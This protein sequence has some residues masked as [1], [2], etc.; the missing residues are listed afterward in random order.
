MRNLMLSALELKNFKCFRELRI[1]FGKLTVLTGMND[2][3]KSSVVQALLL[4][5]QSLMGDGPLREL[6]LSGEFVD[7]GKGVDILFEHSDD[8]EIAFALEFGGIWR[9]EYAC[10]RAGR[11]NRLPLDPGGESSGDFSKESW[12]D[13]GEW[14]EFS[15]ESPPEQ[16]GSAARAIFSES[17]FHYLSAERLGPR[18]SFP[19]PAELS[20]VKSVGA[21]GENVAAYLHR[22]MFSPMREN[23]PRIRV[24]GENLSIV[25]QVCDW[26]KEIIPEK[27][28]VLSESYQEGTLSTQY[29]RVGVQEGRSRAHADRINA[30]RPT[31]SGFGGSYT[32]PV[33]TTLLA[34]EPG[35][36][37]IIEH[38]EAHL[39]PSGQTKLG[40]LA[41]RAAMAGVQV[42]V[43][44]H[45][46]CF[47]HGVRIDARHERID[48]DA[49]NIHHFMRDGAG[50]IYIVPLRIRG[51]GKMSEWPTGFFDEDVKNLMGLL[52]P[53]NMAEREMS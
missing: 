21:R 22:H 24:Q 4:L 42:V 9:S 38:P 31:D 32:L 25:G 13:G 26:F 51:D 16:I 10:R 12:R 17:G 14:L 53:I 45:S 18:D 49:V 34:A 35:D 33:L 1:E 47:M 3:G 19:R 6:R 20:S 36:M 43:E 37:V 11:R 52:G 44:T 28:L 5:R 46:D 8:K 23:D 7:L 48:R 27:S 50:Q 29:R 41:G 2:M 40:E 39:H 15:P 30:H